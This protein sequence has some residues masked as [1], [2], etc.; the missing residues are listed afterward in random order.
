MAVCLMMECAAPGAYVWKSP[1]HSQCSLWQTQALAVGGA[2]YQSPVDRAS[3]TTLRQWARAT[4]KEDITRLFIGRFTMALMNTLV[5]AALLQGLGKSHMYVAIWGVPA[6]F[7]V[8]LR[9]FRRESIRFFRG[10][11]LENAVYYG[12]VIFWGSAVMTVSYMMALRAVNAVTTQFFHLLS[13]LSLFLLGIFFFKE[14]S[15]DPDRR[16]QRRLAFGLSFVGA[17]MYFASRGLWTQLSFEGTAL[18]SGAVVALGGFSYWAGQ[19]WL[20]KT[21]EASFYGRDLTTQTMMS[22]VLAGLLWLVFDGAHGPLVVQVPPIGWIF[23]TLAVICSVFTIFTFH[24]RAIDIIKANPL[25]ETSPNQFISPAF[26]GLF[27]GIG[28]IALDG[29]RVS[30]AQGKNPFELLDLKS[31][32]GFAMVLLGLGGILTVLKPEAYGRYRR[33]F[34]VPRAYA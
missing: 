3:A 30:L 7:L 4:F 31:W 5:Y 1:V 25:T 9:L 16:E 21:R 12:V 26:Q 28:L 22:N 14:E 8:A 20:H 13:P 19:H 18:I 11:A 15:Q 29:L 33:R 10:T 27:N 32:A 2:L 23:A 34:I 17:W 6:F 24:I